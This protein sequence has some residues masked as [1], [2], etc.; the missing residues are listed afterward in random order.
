M[1][2]GYNF[3]QLKAAIL[4]LSR[5][6]EWEVAKKEWRLVDVSEA[7]EPETCLCGHYPIIELCA[8]ANAT[9]GNSVDVG[10]VC[11]KRFLGFRSDLIFQS[12]TRIRADRDKATG[13]DATAFFYERGVI[14]DWEYQ[15]QQSTMR[16]RDLSER[17]LL[18]RR[19]INEK[20]LAS[21]RRRGLA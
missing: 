21:V 16:K 5:A 9:T 19:R 15:F 10:N 11:V 18:S 1:G 7:E 20:V 17:Q 14:N 8:I 4:A 13:P 12:L 2:D 3:E 6:T